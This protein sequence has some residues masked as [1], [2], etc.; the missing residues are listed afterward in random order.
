MKK[1]QKIRNEENAI[2]IVASMM[3]TLE[4]L[5]VQ[6]ISDAQIIAD[7]EGVIAVSLDNGSADSTDLIALA[8]AQNRT[9]HNIEKKVI[10]KAEFSKLK[11][12]ITDIEI[13]AEIQVEVDKL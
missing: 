4:L 3:D 6:L 7:K 8:D 13:K 1:A 10:Y 5:E 11:G 12:K 2:R 9:L